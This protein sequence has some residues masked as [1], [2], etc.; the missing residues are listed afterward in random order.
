MIP[1]TI[2]LA[3]MINPPHRYI[4]LDHEVKGFSDDYK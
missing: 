2:I 4:F 3:I 1:L